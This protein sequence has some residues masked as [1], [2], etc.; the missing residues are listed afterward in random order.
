MVYFVVDVAAEDYGA[1]SVLRDFYKYARQDMKNKWI[2]L[3]SDSYIEPASNVTVL[4]D[5]RPKRNWMY[6][7]FWEYK[8]LP[9]IIKQYQPDGI[10]SLQ[11]IIAFRC[12]R[13]PQMLYMHM[14]LPFQNAKKFS[15]FKRQERVLATYQYIIGR[16]IVYSAKRAAMVIVQG[17]WLKDAVCKRMNGGE[18]KVYVF[19]PEINLPEN[20]QQWKYAA[21]N[22]KVKCRQF[23]YPVAPSLFKNHDCVFKAVDKLINEGITEFTVYLTVDNTDRQYPVRDQIKYIGRIERQEVFE[24]LSECILLFPSYIETYGL[25]LLEARA[26]GCIE[27]VSDCLF[28]HEILDDYP[29][30]CFF[31]PFDYEKLAYY[32]KEAI[33]GHVDYTYQKFSFPD[34]STWKAAIERFENVIEQK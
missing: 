1:L 17:Q 29:N 27:I 22:K 24:R 10:I 12:K 6:R 13:Y 4:V 16:L 23:I 30:A 2:F 15:F 9:R 25:P 18:E 20:V 31:P 33:E 7:L 11:N 19:P 3:L 26:V 21:D 5:S 8:H 14:P 34:N 32:M 28:S